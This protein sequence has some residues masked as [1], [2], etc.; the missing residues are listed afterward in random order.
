MAR[1]NIYELRK[2]TESVGDMAED[3]FYEYAGHEFDYVLNLN[4][5]ESKFSVKNLTD[6]FEHYGAETGT[7]TIYED[8][9]R[10]VIFSDKMKEAYFTERFVQLKRKI[11]QMDLYEFATCEPSLIKTLID[12][13]FGDAVYCG[14]SS[15][16]YTMD[17][18][19][20]EAD[21]GVKYYIGP[22]VLLMH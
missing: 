11:N 1:G 20:R 8:E 2:D 12:D 17:Y 7:E 3:M 10:Y 14:E 21:N 13:C 16:L 9:I 19:I 6:M 15:A 5:D 22:K 18:F 4:N